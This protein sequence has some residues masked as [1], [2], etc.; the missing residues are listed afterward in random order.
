M[1]D[2]LNFVPKT[3]SRPIRVLKT[4]S[5]PARAMASW[6]AGRGWPAAGIERMTTLIVYQDYTGETAFKSLKSMRPYDKIVMEGN[7]DICTTHVYI[8]IFFHNYIIFHSC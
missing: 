3:H 5:G 8:P 7:W 6:M 2:R 4:R 1:G